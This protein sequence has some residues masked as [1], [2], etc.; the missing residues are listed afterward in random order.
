MVRDVEAGFTAFVAENGPRLL[1]FTA[2]VT[3]DRDQAE[4]VLQVALEKAYGSW[5]RITRRG[6][7]E[8]YVKKMIVNAA[9][10]VW[11]RRKRRPE[12]F[13]LD[14]Q[15][16]SYVPFDEI[17]TRDAVRTALAGLPP[18]QRLVLVLRYWEGLT[19]AETAELMGTSVGTVKSQGHR[20]TTTMRELLSLAD[21]TYAAL[22]ARR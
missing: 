13:G 10:D 2:A 11:R 14:H 16:P 17:V 1:R 18:R 20:A 21:E 5:E 22:G 4:D 9:R 3:G 15:G 19:E 7:P 12:V 8:S 6:E